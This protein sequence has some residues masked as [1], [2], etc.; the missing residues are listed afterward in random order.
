MIDAKEF[1]S[2]VVTSLTLYASIT[3]FGTTLTKNS[4]KVLGNAFSDIITVDFLIRE[5]VLHVSTLFPN[6]SF[7]DFQDLFVSVTLCKSKFS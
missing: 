6:T 2:D 3:R 5:I 7:T 1:V 4:L